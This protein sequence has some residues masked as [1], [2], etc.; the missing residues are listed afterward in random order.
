[1]TFGASLMRDQFH[2][3]H[4]ASDVNGFV[5]RASQ[6][7]ATAFAAATRVDLSLHH[8]R[9][10]QLFNR[11]ANLFRI[12]D[13]RAS[14]NGYVVPGQ[15]SLSLIF[16]NF[17]VVVLTRSERLKRK[18][19]KTQGAAALRLGDSALKLVSRLLLTGTA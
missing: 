16:V 13:Y 19:A 17:H 3:E 2:A 11:G 18:I 14:R 8:Y 5:S 9:Q 12:G 15:K 1:A 7:D 10:P 6:L 4:R